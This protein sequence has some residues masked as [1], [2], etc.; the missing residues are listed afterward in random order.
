MNDM[1]QTETFEM[2]DYFSL[3]ESVISLIESMDTTPVD[4]IYPGKSGLVGIYDRDKDTP[5]S[6]LTGKFVNA[7]GVKLIMDE[8]INPDV[9]D[10]RKEKL[11]KTLSFKIA[12]T[13][14]YE[15]NNSVNYKDV[16]ILF[17]VDMLVSRYPYQG[18]PYIQKLYE[19]TGNEVSSIRLLNEETSP[20]FSPNP[21][22]IYSMTPFSSGE[23]QVAKNLIEISLASS[24]EEIEEAMI[25][26][27]QLLIECAE[28]YGNADYVSEGKLAQKTRTLARKAEK[29]VDRKLRAV[30]RKTKDVSTAVD[31][32]ID[33]MQKFI[34]STL[35]KI[36]DADANERRNII[37]KGG[38]LPKI[39][40][41]VKRMVGILAGAAIGQV[42]PVAA[43]ISGIAFIGFIATDKYLDKR[44]RTKLLQEIE[45]ELELV[46]EKIDDSRSD[47]DRKK[48]YELMRIRNQLKRT[49]DK[50]R[51]G[52]KY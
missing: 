2:A 29:V 1:S 44:E 50:I 39:T 24:D 13:A 48:K 43:V 31:K 5:E 4:F 7:S 49:Q 37:I 3:N 9:E 23:R 15:L 22:N 6:I 34:D 20:N 30:Q 11:I 26:F 8:L 46:N 33:P 52:L 14:S 36:K 19:A 12:E 47:S 32:A 25:H 28:S 40:R 21:Y 17:T 45:D 42:V 38:A 35:K 16:P 18:N 41:W 10:T 51:F 27:G